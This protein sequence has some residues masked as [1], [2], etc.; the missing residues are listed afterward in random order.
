MNKGRLVI[1]DGLL[2][3]MVLHARR[4]LPDEACGMLAGLSGR[5]SKV[6]TLE[7]SNPSP[8]TY[9]VDPVDQLKAIK[10]MSAE[11]FELVGIYHSHP[12]SPAVPSINVSRRKSS[13]L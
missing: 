12:D 8:A 11:G 10:D 6:Y 13:I 7:N 3:E 1:P 4:S 9:V 2:D 5:V